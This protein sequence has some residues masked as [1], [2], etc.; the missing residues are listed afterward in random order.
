MVLYYTKDDACIMTENWKS[1]RGVVE[2]GDNYEV[3]DLGK[4]KNV[5]KN[6][7]L[8]NRKNDKDYDNVVLY[9]DG[10]KKSYKVHRLVALAFIPNPENKP[11]VNHKDTDKSNNKM[12]NL[13]WATNSEN[14][15]HAFDNGLQSVRK[16]EANNRAVLTEAQ[17]KEIREIYNTGKY[18]HR[19]LANIYNVSKT[20]IG[21]IL[22][23]KAWKH[24]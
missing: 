13:E 4:V 2:N 21:N 17:V 12:D 18:S 8:K 3:S 6:N 14:Q 20:L 22:R 23:G 9:L 7:I 11:Q 16:G 24:I 5:V 19:E 15:R 1:L 10:K